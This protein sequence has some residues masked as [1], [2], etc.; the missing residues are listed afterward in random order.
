[1]KILRRINLGALWLLATF[2]I[3]CG[4]LGAS[5]ALGWI[6]PLIVI[7]GSMAPEIMTGDLLIATKVPASTL[8]VGDVVSL[9]SELTE[10]LVTHRIESIVRDADG[11]YTIAMKGDANTAGDPLDYRV[12][13]DVW[14]PQLRLPGAGTVVERLTTPAVAVP[15]L[16]GLVGVVGLTWVLPPA[17]SSRRRGSGQTQTAGA[18]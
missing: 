6:K 11:F 10:H 2:G 17:P 18:S 15:L 3:L 12:S 9:D 7:S 4:L 14:M 5:T 8:A 13:G 16:L 1:M